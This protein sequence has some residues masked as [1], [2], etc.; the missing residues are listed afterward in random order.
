LRPPG[1][2]RRLLGDSFW[3]GLDLVLARGSMLLAM[4]WVARMLGPSEFG[5]L[6]IVQ[7]TVVL[8]ASFVAVPM[9]LTADS[10]VAA[11]R[12]DRVRL[13]ETLGAVGWGTLAGAL[14]FALLAAG[15]ANVLAG[16]VLGNPALA[17][18]LRLGALLLPLE[19]MLALLLGI[20]NGL[21]ESRRLAAS[22]A[23]AGLLAAVMLIA[24]AHRY[25]LTG[26]L[27][28]LI[29]GSVA[30]VIARTAAVAMALSHADWRSALRMRTADWDVLRRVG[31][32]AFGIALLWAAANW[33]GSVLLVNTPDGFAQMGVLA[34]ANQWFALMLF[35]PNVLSY[36]T[37]PLLA[38]A[39]S[40]AAPSDFLDTGRLALRASAATAVAAACAVGVASPW[41]M[42][43]YG[44][45]FADGWPVLALLALAVIPASISTVLANQL[46]ATRRIG[47]VVLAQLAWAVAYLVTAMAL[48]RC[49]LGATALAAA[50]LAG[51]LVRWGCSHWAVRRD[52][53]G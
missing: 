7:D 33:L 8:L 24:G 38:E 11:A 52:Q 49:G 40:R 32:P 35:L 42:R 39:R 31:G 2:S 17:S 10:E 13:A 19:I 4:T 43:A 20:L 26:A 29:A 15:L 28:G 41:V 14:A 30:A 22:G 12:S 1:P 18:G 6:A 51:N 23:V 50:M 3:V 9:R 5:A 53:A 44:A 16:Y 48:L 36:A 47:L 46:T 45:G 27:W 25:G 34:A 21:G 37:L